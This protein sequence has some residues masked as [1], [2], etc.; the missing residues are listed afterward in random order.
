LAAGLGKSFKE[1]AKGITGIGSFPPVEKTIRFILETMPKTKKIGTIYNNA[2]A[3]SRSVV[4]LMRKLAEKLN[5]EL[6]EI[7]VVN[8]SEV[9]QATQ[10]ILSKGID[11]MYI[12]GDNTATQA[13]DAISGLCAKNSIPI[14]A[15]DAPLV[16]KGALASIGPGWK[17]V[18][19]HTGDLIAQMLNGASPDTIP[20]EDFVNEEVSIDLNR[21]KTLGITVPKKY[22][23]ATKQENKSPKYKFALVHF[24]DSPNSEDCEKGIRKALEDKNLME[25]TD[26]T[27]KTFNAQGDIATLNSIAGSLGSEKWDLVFALS[28]P[29]VQMLT[30]KLAGYKI[31]FTNVG[32]PLAAGLGKSLEDHLPNVCGVS[33][34]S[35]FE[36]MVKLVGILHPQIKRIG[37]VFAPAEINSVSYNNRLE[38]AAKKAGIVLVSVPANTATEVMDAANSLV[39]QKIEAFC[40]ISDNLTGSCASAILKVSLNSKTPLYGFVTNLVGQGAVAVC[41]RDYFQAGYESGGMATDVLSGKNPSNIPYRNVLKTDFLLNKK[42]AE[43]FQINIPESIY[44]ALPIKPVG[45]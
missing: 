16:E 2:E 44:M 14:V 17:G 36:G 23:P 3:N 45:E 26:F 29:T 28:T 19:Y 18:G 41:A 40:Q 43:L 22:L 4:S 30:K 20:I 12:T 15:N 39:S 31:I 1:H 10:V 6:V 21:A 27:M 13:F 9:F 5:L 37:T 33:T 38:E 25:G 42:N 34:M 8:T 35:D 7:P 11:V 24:V 32:D